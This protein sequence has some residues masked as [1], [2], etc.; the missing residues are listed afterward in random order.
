MP[1]SDSEFELPEAREPTASEIL[2]QRLAARVDPKLHVRSAPAGYRLRGV[3]TLVDSTGNAVMQWVKTS[4]ETEDAYALLK[5]FKALVGAA[6]LPLA[7]AIP[8]P[9]P[10]KSDLMALI[11]MG[12][13]HFGLM[14]WP[15]ETGQD[16]TLALA[17][18]NHVAAVD[19]LVGLGPEAEQAL[20]ITVGDTF[21]A[22]NYEARTARSGHALDV[23]SRW[24]KV[25]RV[26]IGAF[27]RMIDRLREKYGIVSAWILPG[28]HDD[29]S[30][31]MLAMCLEAYYRADPR[32][33][34]ST[35]PGMFQYMEFGRCLIG[36]THGHTVK[37]AELPS[38]MA[39]DQ[40]EAW[41]RTQFRYFYTGHFHHEIKREF[42]GCIVETMRTLAA[43][44][45]W[46]AGQGY[47][48]GRSM[49]LDVLH[50]ERGRIRRDEVGIEDL[51][52]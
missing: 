27:I 3:S 25:L 10:V 23:D 1:P 41:G 52:A 37:A 39:V 51:A 14:S 12:D 7:P 22:D 50:K 33:R 38:I 26:T 31:I 11:P 9:A 36:S 19:R 18:R 13:P 8:M 15:D 29:H 2:E 46:H 4:K 17:E 21:H 30:S 6:Q 32:V 24:P 45:A 43:R 34:I 28:N 44:D 35:Q 48:S 47:R 16:S 5:E 20:L 42:R 49:V 40:V